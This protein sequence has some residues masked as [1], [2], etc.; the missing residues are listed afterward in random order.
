MG[1]RE[2]KA[3]VVYVRVSLRMSTG[4]VCGYVCVMRNEEAERDEEMEAMPESRLEAAT[5]GV[6]LPKALVVFSSSKCYRQNVSSLLEK[7]SK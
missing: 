5:C 6:L 1:T 2:Q 7:E 4:K 3:F